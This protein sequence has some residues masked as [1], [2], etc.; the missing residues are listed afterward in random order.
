MIYTFLKLIPTWLWAAF[1]ALLVL[2]LPFTWWQ[3]RQGVQEKWDASIERGKARIAEIEAKSLTVN[4]IIDTEVQYRDKIIEVAGR[5]RIKVQE[6]FVPIDSGYLGG[7][8]RLF[9]DAAVQ[10]TIPE[11][12]RIPF[13][14][15]VAVTDVASTTSENFDRCHKAYARVSMWERWYDEQKAVWESK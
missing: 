15:P 11:Q 2:A 14:A 10:A 9:Y 8:F 13:A 4:M 5:E 6:V 3:G 7:G 12:S 1:V